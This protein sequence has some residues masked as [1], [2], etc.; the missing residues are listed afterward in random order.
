MSGSQWLED[1]HRTHYDMLVRLAKYLLRN[2]AAS[3]FDAEDVVQQAYMLAAQKQISEHGDPVRWLIRT[4]RNLC[5]NCASKA[6]SKE[7][8]T[9]QIIRERM[10]GNAACSGGAADMQQCPTDE[11]E[12]LIFLDQLLAPEE[13]ALLQQYCRKD[14][15][16]SELAEGSS[17]S[18]AALRVRVCR[19]RKKIRQAYFDAE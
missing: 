1:L 19:I 12:V 15:T 8:K 7:K 18:P 4:V 6:R 14:T 10:N 5:M 11:Q 3:E 17:L 9:Q 2:S 16:L 13:R